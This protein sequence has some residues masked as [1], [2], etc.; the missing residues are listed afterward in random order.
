M[1]LHI[2]NV[3][4]HID[5]SHIDDPEP[6]TDQEKIQWANDAISEVNNMMKRRCGISLTAFVED[7]DITTEA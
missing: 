7:D 3:N 6:K 5:T 4:L 2:R 1:K